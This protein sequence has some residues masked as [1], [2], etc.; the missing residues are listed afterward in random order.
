[1][2][3]KEQGMNKWLLIIPLVILFC[4]TFGCQNHGEKGIDE[5]EANAIADQIL[6]IWNEGDLISTDELYDPG[7]V[8]HHPTPSDHASLDDFKNTV[9]TN[10]SVFP[11]YNLA[12]DEMII[13]GNRIVVLATVTGTNTAP[14]GEI[15]ATGKK[16]H[17]SGIYI[18][19]IKNE[20]IA[21]EWTYFNL[22]SYYQQLG[23]TL[24]PPQPQEPP[25]EIK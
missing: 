24:A 22:L 25:K 17:M 7:Y 9:M 16:I 11:D 5:A 1:M 10:R 3:K 20:K 13:K 18:Y 2:E 14:L 23:F 6:K 21:E 12:F 19:L 4:F 8:R 15:S